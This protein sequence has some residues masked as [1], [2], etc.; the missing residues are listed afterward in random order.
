[1]SMVCQCSAIQSW[2]Q[3]QLKIF[4]TSS[5]CLK[6]NVRCMSLSHAFLENLVPLFNMVY[7]Q[8]VISKSISRGFSSVWPVCNCLTPWRAAVE[9]SYW[10]LLMPICTRFISP[11]DTCPPQRV[12]A[13]LV[14]LELNGFLLKDPSAFGVCWLSGKLELLPFSFKLRRYVQACCANMVGGDR[15]HQPT[16]VF[17]IFRPS[18]A[19][20]GLCSQL[21]V[22]PGQ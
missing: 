7:R 9:D 22:V 21:E 20:A 14:Q 8:F 16:L 17:F 11:Q 3:K 2:A 19:A 5:V 10:F 18:T 12:E 13:L 4:P 6:M 1:M 15:K